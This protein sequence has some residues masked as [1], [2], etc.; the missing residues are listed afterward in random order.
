VIVFD[1]D[2]GEGEYVISGTRIT[3]ESVL[4]KIT[5]YWSTEEILRRYPELTEK[6]IEDC[7]NFDEY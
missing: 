1:K 4:K 5:N 7:L 6:D 2:V 3:A